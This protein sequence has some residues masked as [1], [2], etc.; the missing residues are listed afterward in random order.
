MNIEKNLIKGYVGATV[1]VHEYSHRIKQSFMKMIQDNLDEKN[2]HEFIVQSGFL[3]SFNS[4]C[5]VF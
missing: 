3:A 1:G 4:V 5:K 2:L